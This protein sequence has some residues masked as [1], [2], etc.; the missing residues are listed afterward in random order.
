MIINHNSRPIKLIPKKYLRIQ[1][2]TDHLEDFENIR[3]SETERNT[4][5]QELFRLEAE[6]FLMYLNFSD[7]LVFEKVKDEKPV[8]AGKTK[9]ADGEISTVLVMSNNLQV[10]CD[11]LL[12]TLSPIKFRPAKENVEQLKCL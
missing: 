11:E 6:N 8:M 10:R 7:P 12:Y 3:L 1:N 4:L 9:D 5:D 2:L